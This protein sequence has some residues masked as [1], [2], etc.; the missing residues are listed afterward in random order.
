MQSLVSHY[1]K[2]RDYEDAEL[3]PWV[4][5]WEAA[6]PADAAEARAILAKEPVPAHKIPK[7][8]AR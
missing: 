1:R 3:P 6:H 7:G 2:V 8:S 5:A 4:V